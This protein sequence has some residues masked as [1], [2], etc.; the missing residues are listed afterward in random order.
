MKLCS[1]DDHNKEGCNAYDLGAC[2]A[3]HSCAEV[4]EEIYGKGESD[5][6]GKGQHEAGAKTDEGK[7]QASLLLLFGKALRA[8]ARVGTF[9]AIKYTRGGWQSVPD[10]INRYTDAL[11]RHL[12]A[13]NYEEYDADLPVLHAAQVAWNALARLELILREK[14]KKE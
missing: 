13:E 9:G 10:G 4:V 14:E 5:P 3:K 1:R 6:Y 2:H 11:L 7:P 8:V 12:L